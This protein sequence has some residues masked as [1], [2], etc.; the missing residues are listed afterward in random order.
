MKSKRKTP[1]DTERLN[2]LTRRAYVVQSS[3][4]YGA[5]VVYLPAPKSGCSLRRAA[6]LAIAEKKKHDA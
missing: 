2:Y 4:R 6:D 3:D 1:T 5:L